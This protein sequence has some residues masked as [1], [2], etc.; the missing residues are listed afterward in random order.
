MFQAY[1]NYCIIDARKLRIVRVKGKQPR[2][3]NPRNTT[4]QNNGT[5]HILTF[6]ISQQS[7]G[8]KFNT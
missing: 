7:I 3:D 5:Q 1:R 6:S 8:I 2:R 4:P